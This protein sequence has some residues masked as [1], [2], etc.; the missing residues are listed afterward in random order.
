M[1]GLAGRAVFLEKENIKASLRK[2]RGS[3]EASWSPSY[4]DDVMHV[5]DKGTASARNA[6]NVRV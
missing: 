2:P 6:V 3:E 1:D 5:D 4:N